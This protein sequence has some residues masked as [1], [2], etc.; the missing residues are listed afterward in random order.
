MQTAE[1]SVTFLKINISVQIP[2]FSNPYYFVNLSFNQKEKRKK[3]DK[4]TLKNND[5]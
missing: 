2:L 1:F 5:I 3:K 4:R